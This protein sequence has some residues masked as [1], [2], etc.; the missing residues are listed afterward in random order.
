MPT[1]DQITNAEQQTALDALDAAAVAIGA[2]DLATLIA[3]LAN[4]TLFDG[5]ANLANP[6][7]SYLAAVL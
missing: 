4:T 5:Q 1:L 3:W 6:N 2:A 7:A